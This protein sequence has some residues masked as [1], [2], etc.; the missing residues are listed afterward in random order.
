[1]ACRSKQIQHG[2]KQPADHPHLQIRNMSLGRVM[3]QCPIQFVSRFDLVSGGSWR[4]IVVI[5]CLRSWRSHRVLLEDSQAAQML[6]STDDA[7]ATPRKSVGCSKDIVSNVR[8]T[9]KSSKESTAAAPARSPPQTSHTPST[10][11]PSSPDC[12]RPPAAPRSADPPAAR[13]TANPQTPAS[14]PGPANS[15]SSAVPHSPDPVETPAAARSRPEPAEVACRTGL[16][17]RPQCG[18]QRH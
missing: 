12:P 15:P 10:T 5:G 4:G 13:G 14:T 16:T 9:T 1:M 2:D 3:V 11:T 18:H 7:R 8:I 17:Q 6:L